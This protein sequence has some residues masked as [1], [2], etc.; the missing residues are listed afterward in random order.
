MAELN[1]P[2]NVKTHFTE[3]ELNSPVRFGC[4]SIGIASKTDQMR[5]TSLA[6]RQLGA[7]ASLIPFDVNASE[8]VTRFGEPVQ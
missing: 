5:A 1:Y 3:R 6:R 7:A 4:P 2:C 8:V